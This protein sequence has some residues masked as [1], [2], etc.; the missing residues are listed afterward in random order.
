[1]GLE[2]WIDSTPLGEG[3]YKKHGFVSVREKDVQPRMENPSE[4]W[5]QME[6]D[7]LPLRGTL[8]WRPLRCQQEQNMLAGLQNV[9]MCCK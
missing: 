3:L 9:S 1:M 5:K 4:D 2:T 7:L 8:M 6:M